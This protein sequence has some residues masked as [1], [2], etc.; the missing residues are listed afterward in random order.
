MLTG[1]YPPTY[2]DIYVDG[3]SA[4]QSPTIIQD[5]CGVCN[6]VQLVG[7]GDVV[8]LLLAIVHSS[9]NVHNHG[10]IQGNE[11]RDDCFGV[12]ASAEALQD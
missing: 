10:R 11:S 12:F 7:S 5:N 9:P 3:V 8:R 1:V 2:G 6:Q 4:V